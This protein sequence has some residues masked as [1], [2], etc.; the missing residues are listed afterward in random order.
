MR[1]EPCAALPAAVDK[2]CPGALN[3][4]STP[5]PHPT[6]SRDGRTVGFGSKS[7]Q[8]THAGL[9]RVSVPQITSNCDVGINFTTLDHIFLAWF[10][11]AYWDY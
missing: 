6:R 5:T 9:A 1:E 11:V 2:T 8:D 10:C 3:Y 4:A 7:R